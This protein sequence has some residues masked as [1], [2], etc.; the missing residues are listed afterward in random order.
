MDQRGSL[1]LRTR[2]R[3][4]YLVLDVLDL[5]HDGRHG[6]GSEVGRGSRPG[7]FWKLRLLLARAASCWCGCGREAR[8]GPEGQMESGSRR[9]L[10]VLVLRW[11][12]Q[13][14]GPTYSLWVG[15]LYEKGK[16]GAQKRK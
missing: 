4:R 2:D 13:A 14:H 1:A 15:P 5:L 12:R 9:E 16:P 7:R 6:C 8:L 11:S 3:G 10:R